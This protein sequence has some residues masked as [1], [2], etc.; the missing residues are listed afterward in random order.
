MRAL[1]WFRSDLRTGD[2]AAL[3]RATR[4]A[5]RGVV[6]VFVVC[7][8]QWREHDWADVRVD[9]VLRCVA[10]LGEDLAKLNIPLRVVTT[11]R[12]GGA[13][14]GLLALAESTGCDAIYFNRELEVNEARRDGAVRA[15][16]EASGRGVHEFDDVCILPP[17]SVR[18]NE[19][20]WYTVYTPFRR[21]FEREYTDRGGVVPGARPRAQPETPCAPDPMPERLAGFASLARPDLWPAGERAARGRLRAFIRSRIGS[22]AERRDSPAVNGTSTLSPYLA[23]GVLS[24]RDCVRAAVEANG[25]KIGAGAK[26]TAGASAWIGELVW[27]EFYK[28]LLVA[29]PRLCMGT[30]FRREYDDVAWSD[31]EEHFEAWRLG[32]TGV[33]IVDAAMRQLAQTGWMHNRCRMIAAMF[34]TKNLLIDWRRGERHFMR[35]LVDGDL[36]SNNGGW[37]WSASTGTDAAPYFRVFNP[38]SQSRSHD[39]DAVFIRRLISELAGVPGAA[40]H[41][42]SALPPAARARLDYPAPIVDLGESRRRAIEE[43]GRVRARDR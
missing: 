10:T 40:A 15:A 14:R 12:F 7:P 41:D 1:V 22:Y 35:H 23:S 26:G 16:F 29:F 33:P 31:N 32:R 11:P 36:A 27:R 18:T 38:V 4:E 5:T 34:L 19:G 9:F 37:Q 43:F 3:S 25:G 13:A 20:G 30:S 6:A 21:K 39:P 8:D 17:G 28:H 24:V 42:P 2:N